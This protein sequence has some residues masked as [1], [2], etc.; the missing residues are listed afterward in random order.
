LASRDGNNPGNRGT[1][2]V[3]QGDEGRSLGVVTRENT[4][5]EWT[6]TALGI[7]SNEEGLALNDIHRGVDNQSVR[8]R[9]EGGEEGG[10][11]E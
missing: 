10:D 8:G 4:Q 3:V 6:S 1:G 7:P 11:R 2:K 5:E 9:R